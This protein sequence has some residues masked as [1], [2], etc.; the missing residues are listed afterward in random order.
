MTSL[1]LSQAWHFQKPDHKVVDEIARASMMP[2]ILAR[3]LYQRGIRTPEDAARHMSPSLG[4]LNDPWTMEGMAEAVD[5]L[6]RAVADRE[7]VGVFGDYDADGVTSASVVF[8]FLQE[9]GLDVTAYFPHR[10]HDGYGLNA[11]GIRILASRGCRLLITVDCG[12]SDSEEIALAREL[13]IDVIVTDHHEPPDALPP[14]MAVLNPKRPDCRFPFKELAGVGVAFNLVRALRHRLHDLGHWAGAE[15]PNL[16]A[17]LDLVAIGTVADMVPL[18]EDNRILARVGLEVMAQSPRPGVRALKLL[19]GLDSPPTAVDVAYRLAPRINAAGRMAHAGEAFRL[20]VTDDRQEADELAQRLHG[21]NQERQSKEASIFREAQA[22]VKSMGKRAAYVL[23]SPAWTQGV[24]G[25]VASKLMEQLS[26]PVILIASNGREAHGSGRSPEGLNLYELI[27]AC[28]GHLTAFGGHRAAAGLRLAPDAIDDF[29]RAFEQAASSALEEADF[30]PVLEVDCPA[31]LD[32]LADPAFHRLYNMLEPFGAGYPSPLFAVRNFSVK[33]SAVVGKGHLKLTLAS[34]DLR[35]D[36]CNGELDLIGWG[37]GD[38]V[39]LAWDELEL[40]C[41][42]ILNV[43][44]GRRRLELRLRDARRKDPN[45]RDTN[46][47][48]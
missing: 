38:K 8:L 15:V 28:S 22:M 32:E 9:I 24:I 37:H 7:K 13:G 16:K 46:W 18:T 29:C 39:G 35:G 21:L 25:I 20:L 10:E 40:A 3:I 11:E 2:Q 5:R 4:S 41:V 42:P 19:C 36:A 17:Y 12:I 14:A 45:E 48:Y 33:R 31:S 26:K 30:A 43:W 47:A 1:I 44:Q 23:S 27:G 6:V 34:P